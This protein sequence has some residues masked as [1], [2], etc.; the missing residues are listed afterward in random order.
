M[1]IVDFEYL[2]EYSFF[3]YRFYQDRQ[4]RTIQSPTPDSTITRVTLSQSGGY[5]LNDF[6]PFRDKEC[7]VMI[8][9]PFKGV[10]WK[11]YAGDYRARCYTKVHFDNAR[12]VYF[13][14]HDNIKDE[15]WIIQG[16]LYNLKD[17]GGPRA[18]YKKWSTEDEVQKRLNKPKP[19]Y[20]KQFNGNWSI[21]DSDS[22]TTIINCTDA[23][24]WFE[25]MSFTPWYN[26]YVL[27]WRKAD[28]NV[29][30]WRTSITEP[31]SFGFNLNPK[32]TADQ[33][34]DLVKQYFP[35]TKKVHFFGQ[36]L[37]T[38]KTI[39]TAY[40]YGADTLY[41]TSTIF[42]PRRHRSAHLE[43]LSRIR[44]HDALDYIE[45]FDNVI[46]SCFVYKDG[47]QEER[48]EHGRFLYQIAKHPNIQHNIVKY[49]DVWAPVLSDK[50]YGIY[51]FHN[52]QI[53]NTLIDMEFVEKRG[54]HFDH[55]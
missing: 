26:P 10:V 1:N 30:S 46:P 48:N 32:D 53:P 22:D 31:F 40:E 11:T 47:D 28:Y 42:D 17:V 33:M 4:Q 44:T 41:T 21:L 51:N 29:L 52:K 54:K 36:C 12:D 14:K 2:G 18:F 8:T 25:S 49:L 55:S 5:C 20:I 27:T 19:S 50:P 15:M 45:K 13:E 9:S 43:K 16:N 34:R 39:Q 23:G 7:I 3:E 38:P 37:G 35:K 24:W 6:V